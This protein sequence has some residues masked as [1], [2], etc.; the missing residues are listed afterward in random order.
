MPKLSRWMIRGSF[1]NLWLGFGMAALILS[2]KGL[3]ESFPAYTWQW[4]P[5]HVNLLLVG[6]MV[7]FALGVA[8]W[9]LPRLFDRRT[10]R[11]RVPFAVAAA[12]FINLGVWLHVTGGLI[13]PWDDHLMFLRPVGLALQCLGAL[14]FAYH[15][16]PRIRPM[17][18]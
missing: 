4:I 1:F 10:D 7:Q 6:W 15:V 3:P 5:V 18:V 2:R 12:V 11:G 9:I 8:Y 13:A 17:L 14:S 16:Y